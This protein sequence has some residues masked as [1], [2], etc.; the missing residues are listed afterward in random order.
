M[1]SDSKGTDRAARSLVRCWVV[2]ES[3]D[4]VDVAVVG[5]LEPQRHE[6]TCSKDF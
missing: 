4:H 2:A 6:N 3:D 1:S 5:H